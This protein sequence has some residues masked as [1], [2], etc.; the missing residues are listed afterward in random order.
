[1]TSRS[2][3]IRVGIYLRVSTTAKEDDA[4]QQ[5]SATVAPSGRRRYVRKG[6]NPENQMRQLEEFCERQEWTIHKIYTDYE[7]GRKGRRERQQF[8]QLFKDA[9]QRRFD[10]VLF[11]SLD[12]FTREGIQKTIHYLQQLDAYGVKFK[13]F[14]EP[15]L[16]SDN[17]LIAHVVLGM[18]SYLA[19]HEAIRISERTK[20]GIERLRAQGMTWGRPDGFEQ[21]QEKIAEMKAAGYSQGK[22]S[23]KT[24]LSYNTVKNYLK[25]L[26]PGKGADN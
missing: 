23:R 1:M 9:A 14:T 10:V 13:S 20:A 26:L 17:E 4:E 8:G 24:G 15:L 18:L 19:N 6:Q 16:D 22:I 5:Q 12:R 25:R 21:W 7:S 2:K 11:W 3:Q